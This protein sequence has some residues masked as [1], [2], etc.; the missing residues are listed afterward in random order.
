MLP[1]V[2]ADCPPPPPNRHT[3]SPALPLCPLNA[4][5][6]GAAPDA[7]P[8]NPLAA[9]AQPPPPRPRRVARPLARSRSS[10]DRRPGRS[11]RASSDGEPS[12]VT[13]PARNRTSPP[14]SLSST[15]ADPVALGS[16]MQ[17]VSRPLTDGPPS[18]PGTAL[19]PTTSR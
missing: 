18:P 8:T 14:L 3:V 10:T 19:A 16:G 13:I 17:P 6:Q 12:V 1:S 4:G 15:Q 11:P 7:G 2:R 9:P 5:P